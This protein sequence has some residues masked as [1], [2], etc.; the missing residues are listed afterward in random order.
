MRAVLFN[1]WALFTGMFLI[2]LGNGLQGTVLG[3]R[4]AL[5]DFG[6]LT[7]GLVMSGYFIG[8]LGG[9]QVTPWLVRRVGHVRVF[10]ALAS[11]ISAAMV[12]YAAVVHPAAWVLMRVVVGF[13]MSGVY[14]VA[15]SWLNDGVENRLRGQALSAYLIVQ[16]MGI[17]LAQALL[18]AADPAGYDLFIVMAVAVSVAVVPILLSVSPAPVFERTRRMSLGELYRTSP[19]GC[20]GS[21]FLGGMFACMFGM[22]SVYGSKAGLTNLEISIFIGAIYVGGML[23]QYPI[24]WLS[25]RMDRRLLILIVTAVG[26]AA[27]LLGLL[28]GE[29]F[30]LLVL[31]AAVIG[32]TANPLYSLLVAYTND[33]LEPEDMASAAGGLIVL[34]GVGAAGTPILVGYVMDIAGPPSFLAF[35]AALMGAIA[36][37]ALYRATVRPSTPVD[38]TLPVAPMGMIGSPVAGTVAQ[39]VV[40]EQAEAEAEALAAMEAER[41]GPGT[42]DWAD[43]ALHDPEA[44]D[45]A[46]PRVNA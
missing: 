9:A 6:S 4:G 32:G 1:T 15:E 20:L 41:D 14:V 5:E 36:V 7:M 22:A 31:S 19:L 39:E 17:V 28:L 18:N 12:I 21:F 8:F 10:A 43:A 33:Y 13:C 35:M 45:D 11:L 44:E 23:F 27:A 40:I 29:V 30:W 46:G 3:V 37:Y 16:M 2:M 24:G 34:N 42:G 25:D 38:E 26:A